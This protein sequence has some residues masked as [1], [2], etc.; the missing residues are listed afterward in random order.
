[1]NSTHLPSRRNLLGAGL[2]C[3]LLLTLFALT[4]PAQVKLTIDRRV[5]VH[6]TPALAGGQTLTVERLVENRLNL[7]HAPSLLIWRVILKA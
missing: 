7:L 3:A 5:K 2:A 1:M 6:E 4:A